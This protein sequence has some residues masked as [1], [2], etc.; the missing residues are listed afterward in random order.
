[1]NSGSRPVPIVAYADGPDCP[2]IDPAT[3]AAVRKLG[4]DYQVLLGWNL[5]TPPWLTKLPRPAITLMA[6][7]GL[8]RPIAEGLVH[9]VPTRISSAPGLLT[10]AMRPAVAVV[11]ARR[12]GAGFR[13]ISPGWGPVAARMADEVVIELWPDEAAGGSRSS[14]RRAGTG[15]DSPIVEGN[16]VEVV[17]RSGPHDAP[18]APTV[19][20]EERK[21]GDLVADL[22]PDGA[23]IQWGPGTIASAVLSA[24]D[25]PVSVRTG[26]ATP[27]L[28]D[29]A[30]R[31]LL[32]GQ[33]A[34]AYLWG[35]A[36]LREM[37][38]RGEVA[39][40][41]VD[42]THDPAR[43]ASAP[44]F[45]ALNT[46][47]QIGLDGAVNVEVTGGKTIVGP[48]GHSDYSE[49]AT[50]SVGGLSVIACRSSV[51]DRSTIVDRPEV[52][53]TP[54]YDIDLVVTEH[55]VADLRGLGRADRARRLI[56]IADPAHRERL[57][58]SLG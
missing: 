55:G 2:Q 50:R 44:R 17:E 22:I 11:G 4:S 9:A 18:P 14:A 7:Y 10:G 32:K 35:D 42:V 13:F 20:P 27:E 5:T 3:L 30:N 31:G 53:T 21:I 52:V 46:A 41:S 25:T 15:I 39:L 47:V 33:P 34:A 23:T 54:R 43:L 56:A 49:A 16:I 6:G 26:L 28:V 45:V 58:R 19:G 24:I 48:G 36:D 57:E 40:R 8:R 29:L 37:A 1:M 51:K 38:N 12:A